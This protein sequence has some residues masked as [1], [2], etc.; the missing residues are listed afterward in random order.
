VTT[1]W[2]VVGGAVLLGLMW[3]ADWWTRQGKP[4][5]TSLRCANCPKLV[6]QI[7]WLYLAVAGMAIGWFTTAALLMQRHG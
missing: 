4:P 1:T 6:A 2:L 5:P 7:R 3:L